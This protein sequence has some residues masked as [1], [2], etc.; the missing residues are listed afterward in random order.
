MPVQAEWVDPEDQ[1]WL[2][3]HV[4]QWVT[5]PAHKFMNPQAPNEFEK[6]LLG[7]LDSVEGLKGD[8]DLRIE[9]LH[10][11][12]K[13]SGFLTK[14]WYRTKIASYLLKGAG[15][16]IS[17]RARK[18]KTKS[19]TQMLANWGRISIIVNAQ[20]GGDWMVSKAW[21][22]PV[23]EKQEPGPAPAPPSWGPVV[24]KPEAT[25]AAPSW[26]PPMEKPEA[27][28]AAPSWGPALAPGTWGPALAP[29]T[30]GPAAE[31][32]PSWL[33]RAMGEWTDVG[34]GRYV[35][36]SGAMAEGPLARLLYGPIAH[37]L[38]AKG[39]EEAPESGSI[40]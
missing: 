31:E 14:Q 3:R 6:E 36:K 1:I 22:G 8:I 9:N 30:W 21:I 15:Y 26:G 33:R 25:L 23:T 4:R 2:A 7:L 34:G 35:S 5:D 20:N 28:L 27:T 16:E 12:W 13:H 17:E 10:E 24:E 11:I 32:K 40:G 19:A 18:M 29:G 38:K 37:K 39:P